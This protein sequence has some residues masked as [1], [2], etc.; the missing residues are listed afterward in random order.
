MNE[1]KQDELKARRHA[2]LKGWYA[3]NAE[4]IRARQNA[5]RIKWRNANREK[6]NAEARA[7]AAANRERM[8]SN[9]RATYWRYREKYNAKTKAWQSA[10]RQKVR[11][12][13]QIRWF[14]C[15][16]EKVNAQ[17]RAWRLANR[18]TCL[19]KKRAWRFANREKVRASQRACHLANP[20][21]N[22][23]RARLR[24]AMQFAARV[25]CQKAVN[26]IYEACE[27]LRKRGL[28]VVVDH[29]F[30]LS[31]GGSH[32]A[33]NL[34]IIYHDQNLVKHARVDYPASVIFHYPLPKLI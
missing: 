10:N 34:Q 33:D 12:S 32:S 6:F 1:E 29:I 23:A 30:P 5:W 28:N 25:G 3:K 18:E 13:R 24:E 8:N 27:I 2:Y 20:A 15:D 9:A 19:A 7:Y 4:K 14:N 21:K 16:R 22:R 17:R 11:R 31:K 26:R